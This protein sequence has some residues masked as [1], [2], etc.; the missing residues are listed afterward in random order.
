VTA[1]ATAAV[2]DCKAPAASAAPAVAAAAIAPAKAP[3]SAVVAGNGN[4][5]GSGRRWEDV[6]FEE[7][8][9]ALD[10]LHRSGFKNAE[11]NT[12]LLT[13]FEG[14]FQRTVNELRARA[15]HHTTPPHAS[16]HG[17]R[18]ADCLVHSLSPLLVPCR[19]RSDSPANPLTTN[20]PIRS[21]PIRCADVNSADVNSADAGALIIVHTRLLCLCRSCSVMMKF[22]FFAFSSES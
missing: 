13:Q 2:A 15:T 6:S 1:A 3:A 9:G 14:D 7:F 4:G 5:H 21:E 17:M 10:R 8:S 12:E 20:K 18:I 19:V 22:H 16:P 11:L